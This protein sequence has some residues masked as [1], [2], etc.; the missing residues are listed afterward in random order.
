MQSIGGILLIQRHREIKSFQMKKDT[1]CKSS[2]KKAGMAI[3][4]ANKIDFKTKKS[5]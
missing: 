4:I 1:L 3:I 2:C 5:Y